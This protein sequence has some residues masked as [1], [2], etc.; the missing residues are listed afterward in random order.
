MR[1]TKQ[2][3]LSPLPGAA[4]PATFL[5]CNYLAW[6]RRSLITVVA[7]GEQ[8]CIVDADRNRKRGLITRTRM[9]DDSYRLSSH[10]RVAIVNF[11]GLARRD[12]HA[13]SFNTR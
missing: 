2:S 5:S 8:S 6:P 12:G 3:H 10:N 11:H 1:I 13:I 7:S 4:P 9:T